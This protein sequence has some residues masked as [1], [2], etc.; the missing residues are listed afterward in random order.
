MVLAVLIAALAVAA[1]PA[2]V[3]AGRDTFRG[4]RK[5]ALTFDDR[6]HAGHEAQHVVRLHRLDGGGEAA[7]L[8]AEARWEG[9]GVP[10]VAAF[11]PV[12]DLQFQALRDHHRR[13]SS[14]VQM[15]AE[16]TM[17]DA[18]H[19]DV[20][21]HQHVVR[22]Q[23][24]ELGDTLPITP[25]ERMASQYVGPVG[26]GTVVEPSGCEARGQAESLIFIPRGVG[27]TSSSA[28][29]NCHTTEQTHVHA[30]YDTGSTNIWIASDLC[31][32]GACA[33]KE[34]ARYDH[35]HSSTYHNSLRNSMLH[36]RFGTGE[37]TGPQGVDDFHIG[38]FTV[39]KQTFGL[40]QT[41]EGCVFEQVP[42]EG[43]VGLA[44][45]KMS[46]NGVVPF[47]DNIIQ[48]HALKNNEFAFYFSRDD[49][50]A[51]AIL[52]GGVDQ[53]FY[54]GDIEMF[55]VVEPYYWSLKLKS[56]KIGSEEMLGRATSK[57]G[58]LAQLGD[59][60]SA[61]ASD[62]RAIVDTGTTYF[63]AGRELFGD[64]MSK[65]G[66]APCKQVTETSHPDMTYTLE[67]TAGEARDFTLTNLHYMVQDSG[68]DPLCSPAFMEINVPRE[69][70]PAVILGEVFLRR[71]LA[72]FDRADGNDDRARVGFALSKQDDDARSRLRELTR[73]QGA[74]VSNGAAAK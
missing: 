74:F 21:A 62:W 53:K 59:G 48:Q 52:W 30:V 10:P 33:K 23:Q 29:Q 68:P 1:L 9:L 41:E 13:A 4:T 35:L 38:P 12:S 17:E 14:L 42:F 5:S 50:A 65:L 36:I 61:P 37:V 15:S 73:A 44:F 27:N 31:K 66:S 19:R 26:V 24:A 3:N 7:M 49:A 54:S 69:H 60:V 6:Y 70:G 40:I 11:V 28:L 20:K 63:T 51:N 58:S 32:E 25:L 43:I 57:L 16:S 22:A 64:V 18:F 67:N 46:A 47:F 71:Y 2:H 8:E 34:R 39:Y 55:P 56:F 45:K 72:V